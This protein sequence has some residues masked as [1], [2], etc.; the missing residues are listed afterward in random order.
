MVIQTTYSLLLLARV[1]NTVSFCTKCERMVSFL[2]LP[3]P[4]YISKKR[5]TIR[6]RDI[7]YLIEEGIF[8]KLESRSTAATV[9]ADGLRWIGWTEPIW[10]TRPSVRSS[11]ATDCRS[12]PPSFVTSFA[13]FLLFFLSFPFISMLSLFTYA[14]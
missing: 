5:K 14:S 3:I 11:L 9:L 4:W 13:S 1:I 6:T 8:K 10:V 7:G 2:F 12:F